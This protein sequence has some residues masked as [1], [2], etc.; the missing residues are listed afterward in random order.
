MAEQA[1]FTALQQAGSLAVDET[2]YLLAI[3]DKLESAKKELENMQ[4]FLK[5]LDDKMLKGGAMATNLVSN[6]REVAQE[7]WRYVHPDLGKQDNV[8]GFDDKIEEIKGD[9]MG[10]WN[11][12]LSVFSIVGP[13]GA[14]K[15][16]MANK[17]YGLGAVKRHFKVRAWITVSQRFV[18]RDLLKEMVRRTMGLQEDGELD[19]KT[20]SEI[21]KM[22]LDFL[23][24]KRYLIVLD[25]V[26]RTDAWDTIS[27]AFPDEKNGS[28][29]ILTTRNE[30]VAKHPHA[31]KK[32][33][34]KPKLLDENESTQLLLSVALPQYLWDGSNREV[35]GKDLDDLKEVGK[36]LAKKCRGLP[37]AL[38]VLGAHLSRNLDIA[39]WKRLTRSVDWHALITHDTIIGAI[40]DLSFYDMPSHLRSCF[41]YTTAF[42][43]DFHIDVRLLSNLWVAEGF[44]PLVRDH[45]RE[46]VAVSYV[47]ELVQWGMIQVAKQRRSGAIS[48]V[49]VHDVLRDWGIGRA[50]REGLIK[51]CHDAQDMKADYSDEVMKAYHEVLHGFQETQGIG[52]SMRKLRTLVD[53]TLSSMNN[54]VQHMRKTFD[55]LHHLRVLYLHGSGEDVRLPKEIGRLRYLR[56]LGLGGSCWYCL[57]SS[58]GDLLNLETLDASGGKI[59]EIP[60]S[61]WKIPTLRYVHVSSIG[62]WSVPRISPKSN[63]HVM[64]FCSIYNKLHSPPDHIDTAEPIIEATKQRLSEKRTPNLSYCFGMRHVERQGEHQFRNDLATNFQEMEDIIVLKVCCT[65]LLVN[66][67]KLL[68]L[69]WMSRLRVLE[70]GERSF[71]G[72]VLVFPQGGFPSLLRLV[73]YDL[74]VEDWKIESGCMINLRE[75][76]LCNCPNLRQLP[77]T[78]L[79]LAYLE[80]V[81]LIGMP[82]GCY[83]ENEVARKLENHCVLLVSSDEKDFEHLHLP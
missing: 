80:K 36:D 30:A 71:T 55:A 25:D 54:S 32:K 16:T 77:E 28:R 3:S 43:E 83:Q 42:P 24:S 15:S 74:Q 2:I 19:K 66:E 45:T 68:E 26:W 4:A 11:K 52:T 20:E 13:G 72:A 9:L 57:P 56:Y 75:L 21:K 79:M 78:L 40:L 27:W 6:V 70:I 82:T 7:H 39:E 38:V 49:K 48:L 33:I 47:T 67:H 37:L 64:A 53:F 60:G 51:D 23:G 5:D 34:Y 22:L 14:G 76:T 1:V 35:M 81:R 63:V 29:V 31:R 8:I 65:N 50:R 62:S 46:E 18:A 58:I 73:L 69:V 61:L 12:H 10:R 41:M 59:Y 17:V 44:I